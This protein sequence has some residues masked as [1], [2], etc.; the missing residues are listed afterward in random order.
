MF[1]VEY[2]IAH[3]AMQ[4]NG[5]HFLAMSKS[6]GFSRVAA[7]P[8]GIFLSYDGDGPSKHVF[9]QRRRIPV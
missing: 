9:V 1:D 2:G 6:I 4:G 7:G 8:W 3:H 5:P